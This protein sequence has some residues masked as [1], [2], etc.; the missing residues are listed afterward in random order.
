MSYKVLIT[1]DINE[2]GKEYL[3]KFGYEIK[4]ATDISEDNL[5]KE[6]ED[7]DAILVRMANITEKIIASGKKLRVIS[8][9]GVGVDNI[10]V[11]AAKR[12]AIQ[13]TNS[14]ESNKNSVAEYTM[15]LIIA[16]S[17]RFFLYDNELRKGNS[18]KR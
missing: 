16:L 11:S 1:E 12:H 3:R 6:V 4:F 7:C 8:K 5:I 15:G 13:V 2:E 18:N 10:D 14:K 9:F 17:K